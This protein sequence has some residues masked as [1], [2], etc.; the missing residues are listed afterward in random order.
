VFAIVGTTVFALLGAQPA[1]A[2]PGTPTTSK[3]AKA[4]WEQSQ[5]DAE[6]ASEALNLADVNQQRAAKAVIAAKAAT[7]AADTKAAQ[8]A[9]AATAADATVTSFQ[10]QLDDFANASF[11]G[12]QLGTVSQLLTASSADDFLDRAAAVEAVAA[13]T[14]HTMD[15]AVAAKGSAA[16]ASKAASAAAADAAEAQAAAT[17]AATKATAAEQAA[18]QKKAGLDAAVTKYKDLYNKLDAAEKAAIAKAAEEARQRAEAEAAALAKQQAEEAAAAA[19]ASSSSAAQAAQAAP[20]TEQAAATAPATS[21]DSSTSSADPTTASS[22]AQQAVSGS[23]DSLGQQA[24][25]WALTKVGSCYAYA[26][27]GDPCYDCS[28]LTSQ[29][30]ASVGIS[31][32]HASWMQAELPSVPLDQLEPGDLVTYYSPVSHVAIYVGNGM[33]VSAATESIGVVLRPVD[34]A[35]PNPTGHRVPR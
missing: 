30:W 13:D 10:S 1:S 7:K 8:A 24:A 33:V 22:K 35:G 5:R 14:H 2:D 9:A 3:D 6:I 18:Q 28:G 4:L 20:S 19:A 23:G 11:R 21:A 12:A 17:D 34:G 29:A 27:V 32:D 31:I 25:A 16:A 15:A 26:G